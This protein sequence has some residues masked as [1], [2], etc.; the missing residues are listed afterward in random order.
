MFRLIPKREA[1][2]SIEMVAL[3]RRLRKASSVCRSCSERAFDLWGAAESSFRSASCSFVTDTFTL[4]T[5]RYP[6]VLEVARFDH[7]AQCLDEPKD[8]H[9]PRSDHEGEALPRASEGFG[10]ANPRG[11]LRLLVE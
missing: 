2:S 5:W 6:K 3:D 4:L 7:M 10:A 9:Q 8:Q 11:I 1:A